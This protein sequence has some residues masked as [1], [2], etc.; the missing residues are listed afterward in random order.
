MISRMPIIHF[1]P[2]EVKHEVEK[3]SFAPKKEDGSTG[4]RADGGQNQSNSKQASKQSGKQPSKGR[5][6][7]I[8]NQ[9][10]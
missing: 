8:I 7:T 6:G 2:F 5:R 1:L 3:R 9:E 4:A 10:R